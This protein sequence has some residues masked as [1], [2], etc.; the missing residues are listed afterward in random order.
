MVGAGERAPS[1]IPRIDQDTREETE[2][3]VFKPEPQRRRSPAALT[4]DAETERT[5]PASA[6][7]KAAIELETPS[8][9]PSQQPDGQGDR[10][11]LHMLKSVDS[12]MLPVV[13]NGVPTLALVDSGASATMISRAVYEKMSPGVHPLRPTRHPSVTG[14]GGGKV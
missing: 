14:V 5:T 10:P 1:I 6:P 12:W 4:N 9:G 13:I 2:K 11:R 3:T 8:S 7:E